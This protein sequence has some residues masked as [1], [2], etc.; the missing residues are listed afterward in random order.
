MIGV[1]ERVEAQIKRLRAT[2]DRLDGGR[3]IFGAADF[4]L[5]D[6]KPERAARRLNLAPPARQRDRRHCP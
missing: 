5:V 4:E 1:D 2:F 3:Y 6:F